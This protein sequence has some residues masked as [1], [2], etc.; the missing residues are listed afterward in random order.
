MARAVAPSLAGLL[1]VAGDQVLDLPD[2]VQ[3]GDVLVFNDTRVLPARLDGLRRGTPIEVTLHKRQ[4][5]GRWLA[6]A[7]PAKR[8]RTGDVIEFAPGFAAEVL[9]KEPAGDLALQFG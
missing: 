7:R 8:L 4:G 9:G 6:F 3:A 2:L 5:P 1:W